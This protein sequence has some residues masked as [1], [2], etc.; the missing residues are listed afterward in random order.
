MKKSKGKYFNTDLE[1]VKAV[2]EQWE[3][4]QTR[5]NSRKSRVQKERSIVKE[6]GKIKI[7]LHLWLFGEFWQ[8]IFIYFSVGC[9]DEKHFKI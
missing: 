5:A 8:V 9:L 3:D 7:Q 4:I 2:N 1:K 6:K